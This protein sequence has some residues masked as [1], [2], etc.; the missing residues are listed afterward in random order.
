M[1]GMRPVFDTTQ[2]TP[3]SKS[4]NAAIRARALFITKELAKKVF[5]SPC[6]LNVYT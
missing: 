6:I 3:N 4:E 1:D 5:S 2:K